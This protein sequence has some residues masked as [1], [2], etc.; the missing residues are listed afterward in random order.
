MEIIELLENEFYA[1]F[2]SEDLGDYLFK[3]VS[4]L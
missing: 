2:K 4:E 1:I 3:T